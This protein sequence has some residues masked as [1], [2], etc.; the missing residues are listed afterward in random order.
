MNEPKISVLIPL[1]N[2]KHYIKDCVD[3][4]LNQTFKDFEIIVRDDY[5][6]DGSAEFVEKIYSKEIA[7]GKIKLLRNEKN[8][9]EVFN[10]AQ[11]LRDATGKYLTILHC[12]DMYLP[13]TLEKFFTVAEKYSADV[14]HSTNFLTSSNDGIITNGTRLR[15]ISKDRYNVNEVEIFSADLNDRF[16]EWLTGGTF[17]DLQYNIFRRQFI[18]D[19]G[20]LSENICCEAMLFT[21]IW[22][23][24]AKIFVKFHETV[25]IRRDAPDS[26]TNDNNSPL[27]RFENSIPLRLELFRSVDKFISG[28]DFLKNNAESNYFAKAKIFLTHEN[29]TDNEEIMYGNKAYVELY[30]TIEDAFREQFG[31]NAVYLALLFHWAHLMQFNK[32][33]VKSLLK[34]CLKIIHR[35]I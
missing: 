24:K 34:D 10:V 29:L 31:S 35:E 16:K 25:Y 14:V 8:L 9:G 11:L 5:S 17:Q 2:R 1:Y 30:G 32:S 33:Q 15:K 21:L 18:L 6:K 7:S 13:Q 23:L 22:I 27:Y 4:A 3:S 28:C 20:I 26:Q 12:D 19:R